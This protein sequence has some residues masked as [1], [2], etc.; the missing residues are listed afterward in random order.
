[1]T[2]AEELITF[3]QKSGW[4]SATRSPLAGDAGRRKYERLTDS[5]N[6]L[7]ILMDAP[8][9]LGEDI[10]PF[11]QIAD[12]L[13]RYGLCSPQIFAHDTR[14]GFI[15]MEDFGDDLLFN[16]ALNSPKLELP[17]YTLA[18]KALRVLHKAPP[19]EVSGRYFAPEMAKAA[20]LAAIWYGDSDTAKELELSVKSIL[21]RLDWSKPVL[22]L[23]DYH[24]QNLIYRPTKIGLE[25]MGILDFQDAQMGHS[26]YDAA[27]LLKDVRRDVSAETLNK[28]MTILRNSYHNRDDFD[29]AFAAVSAQRN[30]RILG[31]FVR[32]CIRDGKAGYIDLIP[33]VWRNLWTDLQHPDLSNLANFCRGLPTP[34]QDFLLNMRSRC[35]ISPVN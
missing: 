19:T 22:V 28:L 8:T 14:L 20:S 1:M 10:E 4:G 35:A 9:N 26:L 30:L 18:L 11:L 24:A 17:S 3:L 21:D 12:Y 5:R 13:K 7:A 31:V 25:K 32:L 16:L 6:G 33:R 34:D 23:R 2:R 29:L 27:S 15:L